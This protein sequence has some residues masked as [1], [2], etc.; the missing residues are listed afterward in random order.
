DSM[1]TRYGYRKKQGAKTHGNRDITRNTHM[2][3]PEG[4]GLIKL[5][6]QKPE[7]NFRFDLD[8]AISGLIPIVDSERRFAAIN[9]NHTSIAIGEFQAGPQWRID[10]QPLLEKG[11][12]FLNGF[13]GITR[14]GHF[15]LLSFALAFVSPP[16]Q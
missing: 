10:R 13:A 6:M 8:T 14:S 7:M 2:P 5:A 15:G 16:F 3:L 12:D 9:D 11:C 1:G 4:N